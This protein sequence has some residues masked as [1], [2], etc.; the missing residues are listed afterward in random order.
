ME[1]FRII[2]SVT[3]TP[4]Q[5]QFRFSLF[6]GPGLETAHV[7]GPISFAAGLLSQVAYKSPMS[8]NGFTAWELRQRPWNANIFRNVQNPCYYIPLNPGC[9]IGIPL[10][11]YLNP[12]ITGQ[13]FLPQGCFAV[14]QLSCFRDTKSWNDATHVSRHDSLRLKKSWAQGQV[15]LQLEQQCLAHRPL[16]PNIRR[17]WKISRTN[18]P[19]WVV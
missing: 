5:V 17:W 18:Y 7:V 16:K 13:Y 19:T 12:H 2:N 11:V 8:L 14:T 4:W 9:F 3:L 10:M 1:S 15:Q 6:P